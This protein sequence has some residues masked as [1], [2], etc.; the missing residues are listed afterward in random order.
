MK[1]E[2][3]M[4]KKETWTIDRMIEVDGTQSQLQVDLA[5]NNV[6]GQF[7]ITTAIT[8]KQVSRNPEVRNAVTQQLQQMIG[9]AM[10]KGIELRDEWFENNGGGEEEQPDLFDQGMSDAA[11]TGEKT[12]DDFPWDSAEPEEEDDA[13]MKK[14]S[15]DAAPVKNKG[16]R[17]KKD[18][19]QGASNAR[20]VAIGADG[21]EQEDDQ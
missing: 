1:K 3:A 9:E 12:D 16:G 21:E 15:F 10:V 2:S 18:A 8:T 5:F 19:V 20:E 17:P 6:N 11:P 7:K 4:L 14:L 13:P